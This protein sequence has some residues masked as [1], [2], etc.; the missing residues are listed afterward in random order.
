MAT[1][2]AA[3]P[4][5]QASDATGSPAGIEQLYTGIR[6]RLLGPFR[7]GWAEMIEGVPTRPDTFLF[8]A[9]GGGVWR[10]DDAGRTWRSLF[11][12]GAS[13]PVGAIAIAP[14]DPDTIYVGTGQPE[15][16]YDVA[17]GEGVFKSTDGGQTWTFLGLKETRHIGR[18]WVHPKDPNVVMVAAVGHFFGPN[19]ERGVFRSADGGKTWSHALKI[20][21]ETGAVDIVSD[22]SNPN[23]IFAAA[24]QARQLPWQSYYAPPAGKGSGIYKSVDGGKSWSRLQGLGLPQAPL[25]RISLAATHTARG[26]RVYAVIWARGESGIYRSDDGGA[27]FSLALKEGAVASYY[28]SRITAAP[29]DPDTVYTTGQSMRRCIKAGTEC[30][31]IKGAPGGDDYHSIWINPLHPDHIATAADQGAVVS[32]N[33]GKTWSSWYNQP[34]GQF[35]HLATDNQFPYRIYSGQQDSG[36]VSMASRSDYGA[37]SYR[38]WHPVGADE[39]DYDIPD[40]KD[41][42]IV[43]G[44]GLGGRLSR[45]DAR[46]GQSANITPALESNYGK[47]QT[48]TEHRFVWVTPMAVSRKGHVTLYLAGEKVF[49]S[50]DRGTTWKA[51]SPD[52]TGKIAEAERCKDDVAIADARSCGYGTIWS[53][54]ASPRHAGEI[55]VG[56]D[57][58]LIQLT[59]DGGKHWTNVTPPSLPAWAK[60]SA[61][62]ISP[63][64]DGTAYAAID[65]QRQD[66]L[67]PHI[68]MTGDYGATWRDITANLPSGHFVSVVRADVKRAGLLFA[69]TN[70]GVFVSFDDGGSWHSLQQNLPTAWVRDLA[71]HGDDLI[72]ATQGRAIWVLDD[73]APLRE[74]REETLEE[75]LHLF[76]PAA[77]YRI[78]HNNNKDT[79][80]PPE[81]PLGE[82]PPAGAVIDYWLGADASGPVEIEIRDRDGALVERLTSKAQE[83]LPAERYFAKAWINPT[84]PLSTARGM[85]RAVW[86]LRH[87]RPKA[88]AY[89]FSIAAIAGADT[90]LNPQGPFAVPGDYKVILSAGGAMREARLVLLEDPRVRASKS[91]LE[92]SLRLSQAI[93]QALEKARIAI[94]QAG[95]V[96]KQIDGLLK[97]QGIAPDL[98]ASLEALGK[99]VKGPDEPAPS[100]ASASEVLRGIET[101]LEA[102]DAAPNA[103]QREQVAKSGVEIERL[104]AIWAGLR[105]ADLPAVN[106]ALKSAGL[107]EIEVPP[108]GKIR[109]EP[110]P[111]GEEMP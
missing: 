16:R 57:S 83:E 66:D 101:D 75:P 91:D 72:A 108:A 23:V 82:N 34:T 95:E 19:D 48:T 62:D 46:T 61:I 27:H 26:T 54:E 64:A 78:H 60:V 65:N 70:V 81:E 104:A 56:T 96:T 45:F 29:N 100:L 8:G 30:E 69:G 87:E 39:R 24:W 51:I 10:T 59:R 21:S 5:P 85:H 1:M 15:P 53:I 31:I 93:A 41:P 77:A 74:A 71:V 32:V 20:D 88:D 111:G 7:A 68:L 2:L 12:E 28:F 52:L 58:G 76:A 33:G 103:P 86:N 35:Y 63:H 14:S 84:P 4:G 73:I 92:A 102:A 49:A 98:K 105:D 9:S 11:D 110:G 79:P 47:R 67:E 13:A 25:G 17:S 55:W 38:D 43:Y 89:E 40:P 106:S 3:A 107:P 109:I 99:K 37:P 36:T 50:R 44:T 6:W 80:L 42:D 22:P 94:G 97:R 90:P 18:I